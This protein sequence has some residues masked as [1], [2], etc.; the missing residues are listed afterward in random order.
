MDATRSAP[1]GGHLMTAE[2]AHV[3]EFEDEICRLRMRNDFLKGPRPS[4]S[5]CHGTREMRVDRCEEGRRPGCAD[6]PDARRPSVLVLRRARSGRQGGR[7]PASSAGRAH[8]RDLHRQP[9][10][11]RPFAIDFWQCT[12][13]LI[14]GR[15]VWRRGVAAMLTVED[16]ASAMRE[17]RLSR[18]CW[19]DCA[20]PCDVAVDPR[21]SE[22]CGRP[23]SRCAWRSRPCGDAWQYPARSTRGSA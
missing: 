23:S 21:W 12:A 1:P 2:H 5:G 20:K 19:R 7:G 6:V 9:G 22:R 15:R 10:C 4:S 3:E 17:G 13:I 11:G 8:R 16:L 18:G 14:R